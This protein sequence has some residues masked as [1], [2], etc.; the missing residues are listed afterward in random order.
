[1]SLDDAV[2][3]K[4]R[5]RL[6]FLY[7]ERAEAVLAKLEAK[8]E[9]VPPPRE[10]EDSWWDE[11]DGILITY[12]DMVRSEGEAP[13]STL[14]QFLCDRELDRKIRGVH[15][16][17]F[18]PYTSDDG[19]SV[20]DYRRIDPELGDWDDVTDIG[21]YFRLMFDQVL[22]HCSAS[23]EY[24][25]EFLKDEAPGKDYFI[26]ADPEDARLA[27]VTRPRSLPLLTAFETPSGFKH[28]WTTFSAD[29]VDL[30]YENP[31]V[32]IEM[33]DVLLMYAKQGAEVVRLDAIAYLWKELGTS[34]IHLPQTHEVVK[35]MRD[36]LD[37]YAP[38]TIL[39]SETNV[40]HKENVS[41]FGDGDEAQMVYQFSLAPLLLDAFL[42][43]DAT[44]LLAWL[45]NLEPPQAGTT[46][47]NFTASHDGIGVR[48][49]EGLVEGE[50]FA[51]LLENV[52]AR[53][54]Q[55]SMKRNPDGSES[56][57]ELNI[58]YLSAL[59]EPDGLPAEQHAKRF[60]ASQSI[61][62]T[63]QGIPGIYFHSLVGTLND[64]VGMEKTGRA[65]SINRRKFER[66]ELEA[67][68]GN[69]NSVSA[70]VYQGYCHLLDVRTKQSAF[71]PDARQE[72]FSKDN[73]AVVAFQRTSQSGEQSIWCFTNVSSVPQS[74]PSKDL[75]K[76]VSD[77]L[78]GRRFEHNGTTE[79]E[80]WETL[81]LV[82]DELSR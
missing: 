23:S 16:L 79:L 42:S 74:L 81:W 70:H 49:L 43:E 21:Q 35:L 32:L 30:N 65:R 18:F 51:R 2:R 37:A 69:E 80:G 15:F 14:R 68:L 28:V 34:C 3:A 55:I 71:H 41:Y 7:G 45:S 33:L 27:L 19:F 58:T 13:I 11:R 63:L 22:N 20:V 53:G 39:I 29:Q 61:M 66:S 38:G 59:D 52:Q 56:P 46:Y 78:T 75:P 10:L 64:V 6:E 76:T 12:G 25:Q 77:L 60:L 54:G 36:V 40:P 47:F 73:P 72:V 26:T 31:D 5:K 8:L 17:P 24:F 1:M 50:R 48:P 4:M 44:P 82:E 57:Y 67:V 62:L 9:P